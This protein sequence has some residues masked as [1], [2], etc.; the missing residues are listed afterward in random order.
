MALRA[1]RKHAPKTDPAH[2]GE[3][4]TVRLITEIAGDT[5]TLV[6]QELELFKHELLEAVTARVKAAAAIAVV[7]VFG[8]F[9]VGFLGMSAAAALALVLPSWA[10]YLIVAGAFV[11]LAVLGLSFAKRKMKVPPLKPEQTMKTVKEDVEWARA[12]LKR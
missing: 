8:L 3:R 6:K 7:G 9:I 12:Q 10:A 5:T 1:K 11:F 4:S 2:N